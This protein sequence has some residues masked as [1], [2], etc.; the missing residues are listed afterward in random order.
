[1]KMNGIVAS[2]DMKLVLHVMS[3]L[4]VDIIPYH[5]CPPDFSIKQTETETFL[6]VWP[7]NRSSCV[8]EDA[9]VFL[10]GRVVV[11]IVE[12]TMGGSKI[13][14]KASAENHWLLGCL[15]A[16]QAFC[17]LCYEHGSNI[18]AAPTWQ[19]RLEEKWYS[20][21]LLFIKWTTRL[22]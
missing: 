16:S 15:S 18:Y 20:S 22:H 17:N 2:F 3:F 8:S 5:V 21:T 9:K 4:N 19:A 14:R 10:H 12:Q 7:R 6:R 11:H 1:M 13:S